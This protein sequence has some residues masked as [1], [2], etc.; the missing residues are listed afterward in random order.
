MAKIKYDVT[1]VEDVADREP[2]PVGIYRAK[3]VK[4]EPKQSKNGNQMIEVQLT[5]T[6][7]AAGKKL[8]P[9]QYGDVWTYPI[10]DHDHPFVQAQWKEFIKAFG[11]KPKGTLDTD[12]L[13]GDSIQVKLKSDTDQDGDYRPRVGKMMALAD[14][15]EEEPEDEPEPD[16]PE[17][18]EEEG[19][20]EDDEEAVDLDDLDRAGL[21][22]FIKDEELEIKVKKS[23]SD[24]DIRAAIAEAME[25]EDDDEDDDEEEDED[26]GADADEEGGDDEEED[27]GYESMSIADLK[28]ELK[29]RELP[30][31]GAKKVLIARLRKDDAEP[32]F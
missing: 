24:D 12:K 20:E 13:V 7:D 1:N 21:K 2:A 17:E 26:G 14:A 30:Q 16:E 25:D 8:K 3:V 18:D 28:A 31:N 4:A 22:Q 27:D 10:M 19:D 23:M 5:L 6:H 15:P 32:A 11:L 29:E 9:N